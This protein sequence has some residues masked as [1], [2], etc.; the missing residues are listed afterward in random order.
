MKRS[1]EPA[2]QSTSRAVRFTTAQ[3]LSMLDS[4]N[5]NELLTDVDYSYLMKLLRR[6]C[7]QTIAYA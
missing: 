3:V 5:E 7:S 1:I 6:Q 2:T 4:D